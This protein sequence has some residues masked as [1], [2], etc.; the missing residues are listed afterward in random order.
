MRGNPAHILM[1]RGLVIALSVVALTA[2]VPAANW[3]QWRGPNFNGSTDEA[4]LPD[5]F[6][7]TDSV[8]WVADLPGTS[9]ATPIIWGDHVF[10]SST[11]EANKSRAALCLDRKSG[12]VVWKQ[13]VGPGVA[14]DN[15]SNY[16]S[17]SPA[18]DG[19]HVYFFYGN[20][21]LACFDFEGKKVWSRNIQKEYGQFAFLWTFSTSPLVYDGKLYL[22]VL[23][24]DVAVN[25]RGNKDG[26]NDS[27][28][29]ALNPETGQELWK[30]TRPSEAREE[31]REAFTTPVP[32]THNGRSE[33]LVVG[34]DDLSG[35]DPET[36]KELW[37][38]GTWN[39]QRIGHWRL[40][41]SPVAGA[42]VALACGPKGAPVTA[43]K[44]GLNGKLDETAIAWKSPEKDLSSDVSTPLFYKGRFYILNSDKRKLFCVEPANGKVVWSGD[45]DTRAKFESSPTAGDDRIYMMDHR[46]NVFVV[47][48][49][50]DHFKLL[51]SAA[52]G[53][54]TDN[55]LRS[56]VAIS[57]GQLFIRTG[58]KLY[59]VAKQGR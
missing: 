38:W 30:V 18:T 41:P 51:G 58:K 9:G 15:M 28:L 56:C 14:Q 59:C 17:P 40:V 16:A 3:P 43:V 7:K 37:R 21:D 45:L 19:K 55:K 47:S 33:I 50:T 39:P 23:Q 31:S 57:R 1:K 48:A 42:G 5:K 12:K 46:G 49:T 25:G 22:Q 2:A 13:E 29:L 36:G 32:Y 4:N 11:D 53:D 44:L 34:G 52:M 26:R 35:H 10:V 8:A 24:R 27:Y 54:E 20:G 6:S